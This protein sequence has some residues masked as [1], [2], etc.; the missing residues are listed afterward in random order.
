MELLGFS[1][2]VSGWENAERLY[3]KAGC[4]IIVMNHVSYMVRRRSLPVRPRQVSRTGRPST[5]KNE[6]VTA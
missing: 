1:L 5:L 6:P 3:S 2:K 4:P